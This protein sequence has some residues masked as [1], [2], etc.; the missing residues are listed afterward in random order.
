MRQV[1]DVSMALTDLRRHLHIVHFLRFGAAEL[2]QVFSSFAQRL[3]CWVAVW[4]GTVDNANLTLWALSI[5]GE[6]HS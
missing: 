1:N 5:P 4:S 6:N 2:Q 3:F